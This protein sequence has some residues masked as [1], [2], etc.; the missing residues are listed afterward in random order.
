VGQAEAE[1]AAKA[2]VEAERKNRDL[3]DMQNKLQEMERQLQLANEAA[4]SGAAA[5]GQ[6]NPLDL[7]VGGGMSLFDDLPSPAAAP[8]AA[9]GISEGV[10]PGTGMSPK[11]IDAIKE[12]AERDAKQEATAN[13]QQELE[14]EKAKMR[15]EYAAKLEA[16]EAAAAKAAAEAAA[17]AAEAGSEP[18]PAPAAE[19]VDK[20]A[21][22]AEMEAKYQAEALKQQAAAQTEYR[23]KME[24]E[25]DAMRAKAEAEMKVQLERER[26]VKEYEMRAKS[27]SKALGV[28]GKVDKHAVAAIKQIN[29]EIIVAADA[30]REAK[31]QLVD[32]AEIAQAKA[33]L[34]KAGTGKKVMGKAQGKGNRRASVKVDATAAVSVGASLAS[35]ILDK[36]GQMG[37]SEQEALKSHLNTLKEG[38]SGAVESDEAVSAELAKRKQSAMAKQDVAALASEAQTIA[39]VCGETG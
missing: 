8:A 33:D 23:A 39:K 9:A 35:G 24:A 38:A 28:D 13:A 10:P 32:D 4:A 31:K 18:P 27:L 6:V 34:A 14:V 22:R 20:E 29:T 15:A 36:L 17:A 2:A 7:D 11:S 1:A 16:A 21:L 37:D 19:V 30:L 25:I 26:R 5:T 12:Q 3:A